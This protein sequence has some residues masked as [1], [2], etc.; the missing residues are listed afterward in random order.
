[1]PN[2]ITSIQFLNEEGFD[3]SGM[4]VVSRDKYLRV[5]EFDSVMINSKA[6]T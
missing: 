1:M 4:F 3:L 2:L 5:V 6:L